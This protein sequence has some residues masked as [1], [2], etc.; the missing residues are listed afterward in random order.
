MYKIIG[1]F[2]FIGNPIGLFNDIDTGV[3]DLFY[4][5][6]DGLTKSPNEFAK[7][8]AE[9]SLSFIKHSVHGTFNTASKVT[10]SI[11]SG[12]SQLTMDP[13]FIN[14]RQKMYRQ[15]SK[16]VGEGILNGVAS[17]SSGLF[18]GAT[19]IIVS[20]ALAWKH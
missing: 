7:S 19:G 11:G 18:E 15:K 16:H 10:E 13:D 5:P 2:D 12:L 4:K 17:F 20:F 6:M 14:S 1:S 8:L 9:G 3:L